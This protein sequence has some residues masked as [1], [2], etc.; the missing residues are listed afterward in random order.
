MMLVLEKDDGRL[1][2]FPSG[3]EAEGYCELIDVENGE[4]EFCDDEGQISMHAVTRRLSFFALFSSKDYILA[5]V[6]TPDIQNALRLIGSARCFDDKGC[7]LGS[8]DELKAHVLRR[9]GAL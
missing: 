7:G 8:I 3:N 2:T 1:M 9:K 5:P 6:G 4:Y